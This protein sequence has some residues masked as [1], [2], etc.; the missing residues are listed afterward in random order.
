[1]TTRHF[2]NYQAG[3]AYGLNT[4]PARFRLR[5]LCAQ[6]PVRNLFLTGQDVATLGVTGALFGGAVAASAILH[7]NLV[8]AVTRPAAAQ[9]A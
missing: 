8:G 6:T 3:E 9:A 4:T 2:A 1:L 5:S 7:R